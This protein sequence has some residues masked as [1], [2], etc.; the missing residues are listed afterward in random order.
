MMSVSP[1]REREEMS[2]WIDELE[3]VDILRYVLGFPGATTAW[4]KIKD[5]VAPL[6][7]PNG[8]RSF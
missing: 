1:R 2:D 6:S 4:G 8:S 7:L 5:T 3:D